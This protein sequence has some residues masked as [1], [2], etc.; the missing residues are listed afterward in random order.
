MPAE[1]AGLT[2]AQAAALLVEHDRN[3]LPEHVVPSWRVFVGG[4]WGVMPGMLWVAAV[5][6][7]AIQNNIDGGILLGI[8]FLNA[9]IAWREKIKAGNAVKPQ[10]AVC[11]WT[12]ACWC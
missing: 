3:E 1:A 2:S 10:A 9:T 11:L 6:E 4:L 5:I 12:F 7:F 8:L